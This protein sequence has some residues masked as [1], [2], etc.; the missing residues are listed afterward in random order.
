MKNNI[1]VWRAVKRVS[2]EE[3]GQ[4]VGVSRQTIYAI[5]KGNY[6]PSTELALKLGRYFN[7][8]VEQLFQLEDEVNE[9]EVPNGAV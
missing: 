4:A 2:Q 9:F 7:T 3:L 8:T 5:E 1:R 6:V